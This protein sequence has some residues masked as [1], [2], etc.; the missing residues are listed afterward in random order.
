VDKSKPV[1][2]KT[3]YFDID[4]N[5]KVDKVDITFSEDIL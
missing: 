2:Y 5:Y 1:A 3:E 4:S